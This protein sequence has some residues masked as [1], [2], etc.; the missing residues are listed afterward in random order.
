MLATLLA[1]SWSSINSLANVMYF[2]GNRPHRKLERK[3]PD[4][5]LQKIVHIRGHAHIDDILAG[6][7]GNDDGILVGRGKLL[8]DGIEKK[9][10]ALAAQKN[11]NDKNTNPDRTAEAVENGLIGIIEGSDFT[12]RIKG[13]DRVSDQLTNRRII[14]HNDDVETVGHVATP[15]A[16]GLT[17]LRPS[18]GIEM[19]TPRSITDGAALF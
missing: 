11:V 16:F 2:F 18:G 6:I 10:P 14:I 8:F 12:P 3:G 9:E 17:L 7:S 5:F 19:M 4:R 15:S 1:N 13:F